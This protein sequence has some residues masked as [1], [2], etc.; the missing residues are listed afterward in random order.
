M[1]PHPEPV[2]TIPELEH[3]AET[4]FP[5]IHQD[6]RV[7][8]FVDLGPGFITMRLDT[9]EKHLR[10]GGTVSG[11]TLFTFADVTAYFVILAHVG[12]KALTVTT[13]FHMNFMRK[14]APGPLFCTCRL[15][16]AGQ[17]LAV[18][19]ASIVDQEE[20]IIAHGSCTYS[21]PPR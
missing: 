10:P 5:Q 6:G 3:F 1:A 2:V 8:S 7:F 14:A 17:R 4:E 16:K 19:E 9:N 13:S 20:E 15:L 12:L 18:V 11:P 21:I